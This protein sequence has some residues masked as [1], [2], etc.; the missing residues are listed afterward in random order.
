MTLFQFRRTFN[1]KLLKYNLNKA[2]RVFRFFDNLMIDYLGNKEVLRN[3]TCSP[4]RYEPHVEREHL[5]LLFNFVAKPFDY[6]KF[7]PM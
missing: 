6:R 7:T 5:Y 3:C 2:L 1:F 4:W